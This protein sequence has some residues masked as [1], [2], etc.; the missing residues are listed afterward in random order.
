MHNLPQQTTA[1]PHALPNVAGRW[2]GRS[3]TAGS[4]VFEGRQAARG[5]D[6]RCADPLEGKRSAQ[7]RRREGVRD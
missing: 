4:A 3:G 6:G 5:G 1:Y 7:R 2:L